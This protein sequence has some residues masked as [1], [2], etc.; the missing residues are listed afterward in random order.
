MSIYGLKQAPRAWYTRLKHELDLRGFIASGVDPGLFIRS[1]GGV[2][3]FYLVYV[4][5]LLLAASDTHV[6]QE[7]KDVLSSIF[8]LR[9]MGEEHTSWEWRFS[10]TGQSMSYNCHRDVSRL[11]WCT[12]LAFPMPKPSL[13]PLVHL[14][15]CHVMMES[16]QQI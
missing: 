3:S 16:L 1:T 11:T 15:V 5:D 6:V 4:D 10:A 13:F 14:H 7:L 8:D 2:V 9:D 12:S